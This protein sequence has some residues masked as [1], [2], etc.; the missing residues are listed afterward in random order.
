M[1]AFVVSLI[2]CFVL[3]ELLHFARVN[4]E[5]SRKSVH[6]GSCLLI[7]FY[8][9]F[10]VN[11]REL[12]WIAIGFLFALAALRKSRLLRAIHLVKRRSWGDLLLPLSVF[13]LA[14]SGASQQAFLAAYLV[15]GVADAAASVIGSRYGRRP[16]PLLRMS[17]TWLGS[18]AFLTSCLIMLSLSVL[19]GD[20]LSRLRAG[21][22]VA[23]SLSLTVVEAVCSGGT[24]NLFVPLSAALFFD[25]VN[26]SV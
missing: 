10:G 15:L 25:V 13:V 4:A 1:L 23:L 3:G 12:A 19:T 2:A 14:C 11:R 21:T 5:L 22:I 17:K 26:S 9:R 24:D 16:L 8:P 6:L 7:A 20:P 18:A